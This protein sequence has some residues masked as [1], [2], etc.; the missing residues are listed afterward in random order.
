MEKIEIAVNILKNALDMY[1][2]GNDLEKDVVNAMCK[3]INNWG[4]DNY[5]KTQTDF[6]DL[7]NKTIEQIKNINAHNMHF[8]ENNEFF[9]IIYID[10]DSIYLIDRNLDTLIYTVN[11]YIDVDKF[12]ELSKKWSHN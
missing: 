6:F 12:L 7:D 1:K 10:K 3:E 5:F 2:T 4:F 9:N 8:D 11:V